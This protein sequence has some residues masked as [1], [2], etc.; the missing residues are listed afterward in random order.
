M[1][2]MAPHNVIVTKKNFLP[3]VH[4]QKKPRLTLL[5][6]DFARKPIKSEMTHDAL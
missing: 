5:Y 1:A 2:Q 4:F 3:V 6:D